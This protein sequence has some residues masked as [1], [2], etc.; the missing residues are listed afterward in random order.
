MN[1][2][3]LYDTVQN[4]DLGVSDLQRLHDDI[5]EHTGLYVPSRPTEVEDW[6]RRKKS[7]VSRRLSDEDTNGE[8]NGNQEQETQS[9]GDNE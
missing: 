8:V 5:R 6:W 7:V 3:E 1:E 9:E 4:N 2:E